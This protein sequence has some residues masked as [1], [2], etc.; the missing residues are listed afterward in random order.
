MK[1]KN[2]KL[3][4]RSTHGVTSLATMLILGSIIVQIGLVGFALSYYLTTSNAGV[5]FSSYALSAAQAG[6][7][8][9]MLRVVRGDYPPSF[10]VTFL[11][12]PGIGATTASVSICDDPSC[13]SGLQENQVR[14]SSSATE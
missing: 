6:I 11:A 3:K 14:I 4:I 9:G 10:P 5:K 8:E 7:A 12:V 2:W 1:I 13:E